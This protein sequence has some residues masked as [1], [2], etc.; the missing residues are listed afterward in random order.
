MLKSPDRQYKESVAEKRERQM[1]ELFEVLVK[2][3]CLSKEVLPPVEQAVLD[4][5]GWALG[6]YD[7]PPL[8]PEDYA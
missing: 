3:G 5:L 8:D 1:R 6:E 2:Q 7:T 4:T